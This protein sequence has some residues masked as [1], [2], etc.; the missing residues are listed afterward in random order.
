MCRRAGGAV[1]QSTRVQ[2]ASDADLAPVSANAMRS[3]PR[4]RYR[5]GREHRPAE[6]EPSSRS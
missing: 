6:A 1:V 4:S 3:V 5:A 2:I